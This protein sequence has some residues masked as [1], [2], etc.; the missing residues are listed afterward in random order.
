MPHKKSSPAA[1]TRGP[2]APVAQGRAKDG[3]AQA[4]EQEQEA[5]AQMGDKSQLSINE[6]G[7]TNDSS[8]PDN[9]KGAVHGLPQPAL[10][11]T[12]R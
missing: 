10:K 4:L 8:T 9:P 11:G 12:W 7:R 6:G 2:T 3:A 1:P 5:L